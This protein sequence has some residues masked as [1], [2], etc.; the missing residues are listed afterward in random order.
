MDLPHGTSNRTNEFGI[1][2]LDLQEM[3]RR[4]QEKERTDAGL[5][6]RPQPVQ[7]LVDG[8]ER[9]EGPSAPLPSTEEVH[10]EREGEAQSELRRRKSWRNVPPTAP[11]VVDW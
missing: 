4:K 8:E 3:E 1:S 2:G 5:P 10:S 6:Q 9:K 11:L 7:A